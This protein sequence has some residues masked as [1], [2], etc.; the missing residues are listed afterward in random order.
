MPM[1][2]GVPQA[3]EQTSWDRKQLM[4]FQFLRGQAVESLSF[5]TIKVLTTF[6]LKREAP[7]CINMV[8]GKRTQMT[9]K[10]R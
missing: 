1:V 7:L 9:I 5:T 6:I 10:L 8:Q 2:L 4:L 3:S